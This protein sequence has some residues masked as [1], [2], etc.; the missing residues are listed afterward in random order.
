MPETKKD[1]V[2]W[3]LLKTESYPTT[4]SSFIPPTALFSSIVK[5]KLFKLYDEPIKLLLKK[6]SILD[7][8]NLQ[9]FLSNTLVVS[10]M[11]NVS[12]AAGFIIEICGAN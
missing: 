12:C 9:L 4:R 10:P 3:V 8:G 1:T 11:W 2:V 7:I 5:E 6:K